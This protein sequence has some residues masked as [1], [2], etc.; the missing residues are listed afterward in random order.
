MKRLGVVVSVAC[1]LSG[2]CSVREQRTKVSTPPV[3]VDSGRRLHSSAF[4]AT[5][6][7]ES[8]SRRYGFGYDA[9][10]NRI[11]A[12]GNIISPHSRTP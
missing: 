4:P 8:E 5:W 3:P 1:G 11:D 12:N 7:R 2:A 6:H 9:K 10:G